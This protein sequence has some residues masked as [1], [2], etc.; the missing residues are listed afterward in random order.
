[1]KVVLVNPPRGS[2]RPYFLPVQM[3]INIA[4]LAGYLRRGDFEVEIWD[5]EVEEFS[6]DLF[7]ER[8]I[9]TKPRV[10][11]FGCFTPSIQSGH[12]LAGLVKQKISR[13]I[14]VAGGVHISA[15][16]GRSLREFSDFDYL[17][18]GEGEKT[19][20]ELCQT[21]KDRN[22]PCGIKG[23]LYREEGRNPKFEPRPLIADLD[24]V[25]F[26]ARD[27]LKH[28]LYKGAT[29]NRFSRSY[30]NIA[31]VFT[32]R[33]CPYECIFCASNVTM[34]R[35]IRFRSVDNICEEIS[36]CIKTHKTNHIT[37]LDDTFTLDRPR[38]REIC[39]YLKEKNLTWNAT[40]TRV[41]AVDQELLVEMADSGCAGLTF[42]VES[43][44][45]RILDLLKKRID[46][47]QVKDAFLWTRQAGIQSIE[48]D[49]IIG[50]HPDE[51]E[52][53]LALTKILIKELNP[54]ILAVS[55]VVPY[56]G[57]EVNRLMKQMNFLPETENWNDFVLF[58]KKKPTWHTT[59]FSSNDLFTLQRKLLKEYY[60][61]FS[62]IVRRVAKFRSIGEFFYWGKSVLAF[63]RFDLLKRKNA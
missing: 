40:G 2:I 48:A 63:I 9:A 59:H 33:G 27:L 49:F 60:F 36:D 24:E 43:G 32:A 1:M 35:K 11:G 18:V 13:T 17:V 50:A 31:E 8:L 4:Y 22:A 61:T 39:R 10:V 45:Q 15:V 62:Y 38:I 21:I 5:F 29:H 47:K 7:I 3:P 37:F 6:D 23:L 34:G 26:P 41:N 55:C 58:G 44:S 14:T 28:H 51:T 53:D 20:F 19:F 54:D 30:L 25:P 46:L 12:H 57:T 52:H 42:G 16:P 56:P